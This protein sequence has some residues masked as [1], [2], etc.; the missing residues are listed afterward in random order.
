MKAAVCHEFGKPLVI[1]EVNLAEPKAG[2]VRMTPKAFL[3]VEVK[4]MDPP[5]RACQ[6]ALSQQ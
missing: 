3:V 2:E 5:V 4:A 1:E 6:P